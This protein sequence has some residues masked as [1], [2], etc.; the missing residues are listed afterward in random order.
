[1]VDAKVVATNSVLA[2][3]NQLETCPTWSPDGK[4]LYFCRAPI[5]WT[6]RLKAPPDGYEKIRYNLMRISYDVDKDQWGQLETVLSADQTKKSILSPR[7]SPDGRFLLFCMCDHSCFPLYQQDSDL[8]MMD[9]Q[10]GQYNKLDI[11][12]EYSESWH[13]WSSN[14]RWIVFSSKRQG[15]LFTRTYISYFDKSAKPHK[16]FIL[17]QKDP[18]FYDSYIKSHNLP[19]LITAPLDVGNR[20]FAG[21]TRSSNEIKVLLPITGAT[22]KQSKTVQ[23]YAPRE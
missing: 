19:E 13:S 2:D 5:T 4:Y 1:M 15:T 3:A 17:P 8:Y 22:T 6:N 20:E 23:E 21:A 9:L 7:I 14:G 10:T 18:A 11:N 12:S 16:P